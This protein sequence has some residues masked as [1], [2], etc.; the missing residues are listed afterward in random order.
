MGLI[1]FRGVDNIVMIIDSHA[2][3]FNSLFHTYIFYHS[4]STIVALI[5]KLNITVLKFLVDLNVMFNL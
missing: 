3:S 1:W 2:L 5:Y 4:L